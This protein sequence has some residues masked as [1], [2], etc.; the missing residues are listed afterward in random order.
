MYPCGPMQLQ[1][2]FE[3]ADGAFVLRKRCLVSWERGRSG[4]GYPGAVIRAQVGLQP[5]SLFG[6]GLFTG[7]RP[8]CF[9]N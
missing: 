4:S 6:E 8:L 2:K 3:R 7:W 5:H 1:Q 9:K